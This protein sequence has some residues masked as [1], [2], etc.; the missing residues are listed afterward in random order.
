MTFSNKEALIQYRLKKAKETLTAAKLLYEGKQWNSCVNRLYYA[1]FYAVIALLLKHSF[2]AHTHNGVRS[3][4]G[5]QFIKTGF[6]SEEDG[7][8]F[9]QLFTKRQKGDYGDLFDFNL[10][11]VSPFIEPVEK[12]IETI[13][14]MINREN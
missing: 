4:L 13:E 7:L 3:I 9:N 2:T 14:K 8:L 1:C 11:S 12:F 10:E 5:K 6:L